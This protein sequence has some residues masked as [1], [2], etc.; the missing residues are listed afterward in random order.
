M[1]NSESRE[2]SGVGAERVRANRQEVKSE[3][4]LMEKGLVNHIKGVGFI[5]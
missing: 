4:G 3:L 2:A 5:W 1:R